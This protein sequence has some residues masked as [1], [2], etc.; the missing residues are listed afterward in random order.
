MKTDD[1]RI[2]FALVAI[3]IFLLMNIYIYKRFLKKIAFLSNHHAK[4]RWLII[5]LFASEV[6]YFALLPFNLLSSLWYTLFSSFIGITFMLFVIAV[7][8]DLLHISIHAVTFDASRRKMMKMMLDVT[9]IVAVAAYTLK[10]FANGFKDPRI[11]RVRVAI[12]NLETPFRIVQIS[13]LHI[14]KILGRGF[15]Q[16]VVDMVNALDADIVV[17]TGDLVDLKAEEL[18]NV[19]SPLGSVK[20]R[21]GTFFVPGNHEYFHGAEAIMAHVQNLGIRVLQNESVLVDHRINLAGTLDMIGERFGFLKPDIQKTLEHC[22]PAS[23]TV[24]LSHQPK[25]VKRLKNEPIDLILSGHTHGGQIFPFGLLVMLDQ[26]YLSGLYRHSEKTQ[27][28]VT[29]G[30]G[31]WGPPIRV[32]APSEIAVITLEPNG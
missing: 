30:T 26:P 28:F 15:L 22:D 8:Y 18:G 32:M 31:Y 21:H 5:T 19:L 24:M 13:D 11:R 2:L 20:S 10:G 23:P 3:S 16:K 17:I 25:I 9:M 27:V 1:L 6:I 29:N 4:L 12:D 14:G 7:V